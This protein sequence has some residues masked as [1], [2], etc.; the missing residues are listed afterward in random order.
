MKGKREREGVRHV[1]TSEGR[2][3][4]QLMYNEENYDRL[5]M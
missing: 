1:N 4:E 3:H 5:H 2:L